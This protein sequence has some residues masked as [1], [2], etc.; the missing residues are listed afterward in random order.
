MGFDFLKKHKE[1]WA[2]ADQT[3]Q[4]CQSKIPCDMDPESTPRRV[5]RIST[6]TSMIIPPRSEVIIAGIVHK[7]PNGTTTGIVRPQQ[8]FL[9]KHGLGIATV[10][11][12][13]QNNS[14]PIRII[15]ASERPK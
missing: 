8:Q 2:W 11:V 13:Q 14:V 7:R 3:L 9:E 10:F 5:A 1:E 4:I 6:R 15:N 12:E